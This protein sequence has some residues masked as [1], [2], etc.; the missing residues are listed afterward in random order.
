MSSSAYNS[1]KSVTVG[2][3]MGRES[4]SREASEARALHAH[5]T[6]VASLVGGAETV[7]KAEG[8]DAPPA[9]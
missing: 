4:G 8:K 9:A 6:P 7:R 3:T 2:L 1:D 5:P